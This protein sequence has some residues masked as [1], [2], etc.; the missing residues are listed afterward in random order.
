MRR[1]FLQPGGASGPGAVDGRGGAAGAS[2]A[3]T[4]ASPSS[5]AAA[6]PVPPLSPEAFRQSWEQCLELLRADSDEKK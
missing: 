5:S 2:P 3:A 6:A 1:G 4:A